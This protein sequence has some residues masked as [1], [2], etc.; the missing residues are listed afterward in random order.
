MSEPWDE[1]VGPIE[2]TLTAGVKDIVNDLKDEYKS[3]LKD[4]AIRT[5]KE[6]WRSIHGSDEE[7][8]IA[9]ANLALLAG[10]TVGEAARMALAESDK[11]AAVLE[12]VLN[13][14][15]QFAEHVLV[16]LAL[17]ALKK[18]KF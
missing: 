2:S 13:T 6:T 8:E 18:E 4:V 11:A 12:S 14:A 5:A 3:F 15:L 17:A 9:K 1:L 7:K 16:P 10:K